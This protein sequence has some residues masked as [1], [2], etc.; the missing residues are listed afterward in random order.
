MT[1]LCDAGCSRVATTPGADGADYCPE[2]Y[3][4]SKRGRKEVRPRTETVKRA[5][6]WDG[7][8]DTYRTESELNGFRPT[9]GALI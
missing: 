8:Q 9:Q 7:V 1:T 4:A 2:C 3:K 6:L 5:S